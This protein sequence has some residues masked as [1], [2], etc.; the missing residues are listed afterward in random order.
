MYEVK[1][2]M[3]EKAKVEAARMEFELKI[4]SAEMD[5]ERLINNISVQEK[6]IEQINQELKK[7]QGA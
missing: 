7:L 4:M 1:K 6:R 5:I 3:V 2:L